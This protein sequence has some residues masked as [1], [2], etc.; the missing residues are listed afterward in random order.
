MTNEHLAKLLGDEWTVEEEMEQLIFDQVIRSVEAKEWDD[1]L[2]R[3]RS[4]ANRMQAIIDYGP[5]ID[6]R[7]LSGLLADWWPEC[8]DPSDYRADSWVRLFRHAGLVTDNPEVT[9]PTTDLVIYRGTATAHRGAGKGLSWTTDYER[10]S[11]FARRAVMRMTRHN[12]DDGGWV[13][14]AVV[15]PKAV[16]GMFSGRDEAEV[17]IAPK[18]RSIRSFELFAR[19]PGTSLLAA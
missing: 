16:L 12:S 11:W 2:H 1:A 8:E 4:R 10:A 19:I 15:G 9:L 5:D 7:I 17:V 18:C 3:L 13:W 6:A 14:Q